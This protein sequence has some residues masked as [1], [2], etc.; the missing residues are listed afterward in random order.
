MTPPTH[1]PHIQ[2]QLDQLTSVMFG[3]GDAAQSLSCELVTYINTR[4]WQY[5]LRHQYEASDVLAK[6][7]TKVERKIIDEEIQIKG[8]KVIVTSDEEGPSTKEL[9]FWLKRFLYNDVRDLSKKELRFNKELTKLKSRIISQESYATLD[10][11]IL[12]ISY[13]G[14]D[15]FQK[16]SLQKALSKLMPNDKKILFLRHVDDLKWGEIGKILNISEASARKKGNRAL[17]RLKDNFH[18]LY[19]VSEQGG[20]S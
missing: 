1:P 20:E 5:H 2:M 12:S 6:T 17:K 7:Y 19:P 16:A 14:R 13:E 3:Q 15:K 11:N 18:L 10:S 8:L 9:E 4:L